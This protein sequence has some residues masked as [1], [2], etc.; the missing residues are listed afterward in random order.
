MSWECHCTRCLRD[1][2]HL[3]W[4]ADPSLPG[5]ALP[6]CDSGSILEEP[7]EE[8]ECPNMEVG[9]ACMPGTS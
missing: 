7:L 3:L 8:D 2:K 9:R 6:G 5:L 1:A 4:S